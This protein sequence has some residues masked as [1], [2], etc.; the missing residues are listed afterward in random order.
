LPAKT[1]AAHFSRRASSIRNCGITGRAR[2]YVFQSLPSCSSVSTIR[3]WRARHRNT[4]IQRLA[5]GPDRQDAPIAHASPSTKEHETAPRSRHQ[6]NAERGSVTM[7]FE[8]LDSRS[9]TRRPCYAQQKGGAPIWNR[10]PVSSR[11]IGRTALR[12]RLADARVRDTIQLA[13][14]VE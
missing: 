8:G 14:L 1:A 11:V 10:P 12:V 5:L 4:V 7:K 13:R 9:R 2:I 6:P 3:H